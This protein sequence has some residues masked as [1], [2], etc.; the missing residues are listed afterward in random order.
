M[1]RNDIE[2]TGATPIWPLAPQPG[3]GLALNSEWE[4]RSYGGSS[5]TLDLNLATIWRIVAEWRWLIVGA[6]AVAVAGAIVITFLTTP[7]YRAS[8]M[9]EINPPEVEI[10]EDA[11][12]KSQ[13]GTQREYLA[14]QYGLL[15]SRSLA[16]R[17]AQEM[18]LA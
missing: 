17:V 12:A 2:P 9:I 13:S 7:L 6:V 10:L 3:S 11:K 8:V 15:A 14:T 18:N 5:S 16:E 1:S 4:Q